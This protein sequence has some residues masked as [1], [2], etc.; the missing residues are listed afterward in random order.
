MVVFDRKTEMTKGEVPGTMYGLSEV[1]GL[2][3]NFLI[4]GSGIIF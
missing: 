2:I 4:L 1:V 3:V